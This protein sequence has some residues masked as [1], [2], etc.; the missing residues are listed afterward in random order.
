MQ[1]ERQSQ[2]VVF[3]SAFILLFAI[4]GLF[5]RPGSASTG[6]QD[7]WLEAW[8]SNQYTFD[9]NA[10]DILYGELVVKQDG[11]L[12]PGDQTKYDIWLIQ[13]V[14]VLVC[15]QTN[16]SLWLSGKEPAAIVR[17]DHVSSFSWRTEVPGAGLW[18]II[19]YSDSIFR[20]HLE[21][22]VNQ[23]ASLTP[24]GL[25]LMT[26]AAVLFALVITSVVRFIRLR[27]RHGTD[28]SERAGKRRPE[29]VKPPAVSQRSML[30][31]RRWNRALA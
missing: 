28:R 18:Y 24:V 10:H 31:L 23:V 21:V 6:L 14:N 5:V 4:Q 7:F 2:L 16:Y 17:G 8:S 9:C 25:V 26:S 29:T 13:G 3:V 27:S 12:F 22:S 11:D 15:N 19:C 30:T 1:N 20:K